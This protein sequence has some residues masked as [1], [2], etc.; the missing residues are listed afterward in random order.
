MKTLSLICGL[1]ILAVTLPLTALAQG[2][3][4]NTVLLR[5]NDAENALEYNANGSSHGQCFNNP[6]NGCVRATSQATITFRLVNDRRCTSGAMWELSGV[7]LGGEGSGSKPGQ[8]GG[9]RH[10]AGDFNADAGSGWAATS[11]SRGQSITMNDRNSSQYDIW[12]RVRASCS[13]HPDIYFDPRI[14]NDGTGQ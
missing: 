4:S 13:G 10:A 3:A 9:L 7:Q 6:G 2:A 1:A 14:E 11:P 12:Y 8:F 5:V